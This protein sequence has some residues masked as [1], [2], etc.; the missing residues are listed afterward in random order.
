[1]TLIWFARERLV[2]VTFCL[3]LVILPTAIGCSPDEGAANESEYAAASADNDISQMLS[4]PDTNDTEQGSS[5]IKNGDVPRP[6]R[7]E[8]WMTLLDSIMSNPGDP[9]SL[10]GDSLIAQFEAHAWEHITKTPRGWIIDRRY[11]SAGTRSLSVGTGLR[12]ERALIHFMGQDSDLYMLP[13]RVTRNADGYTFRVQRQDQLDADPIHFRVFFVDDERNVA[14]WF[15]G[16]G[17]FSDTTYFVRKV[18]GISYP[19]VEDPPC[20]CS[21][22]S[23]TTECRSADTTLAAKARTV[24]QRLP[25]LDLGVAFGHRAFLASITRAL[26]RGDTNY[27]LY[28][29]DGLYN[30]SAWGPPGNVLDALN[31]LE[32]ETPSQ[33]TSA[34]LQAHID[35]IQ[36]ATITQALS[37]EQTADPAHVV[38]ALWL[39]WDDG[40]TDVR[41]LTVS[42]PG[43]GRDPLLLEDPP[44]EHADSAADSVRINRLFPD[45]LVS[46]FQQPDSTWLPL[47]YNLEQPNTHV[48]ADSLLSVMEGKWQ[49]LT[50]TDRG[51]IISH[52]DCGA[53]NPS[54]TFTKNNGWSM[55]DMGGQDALDYDIFTPVGRDSAS[56]RMPVRRY[57]EDGD[58]PMRLSVVQLFGSYLDVARIGV[59]ITSGTAEPLDLYI[60]ENRAED[61]PRVGDLPCRCEL[62]FTDADCRIPDTT[63]SA[64]VRPIDQRVRVDVDVPGHKDLLDRIT[65]AA[66]RGDLRFLYYTLDRYTQASA[67]GFEGNVAQ[68]FNLIELNEDTNR[69]PVEVRRLLKHIQHATITRILDASEKK[70]QYEVLIRFNDGRTVTTSIRLTTP[71]TGSSAIHMVE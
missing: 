6:A 9:A 50:N 1:M 68:A 36:Q 71:G 64:T 41:P 24:R 60:R 62:H 8:P 52:R 31:L 14:G 16:E 56:Y 67:W 48:P 63:L 11:C 45:T 61:V 7:L 26:E 38:Y 20:R 58:D 54:I 19:E 3:L 4:G 27:L 49:L 42:L 47:S 65:R 2:E 12:T 59:D 53:M 69:T 34:E 29:I 40:R 21:K 18:P 13:S 55:T 66:E 35:Q 30:V 23:M 43:E 57:Y 33:R 46:P 22:R 32:K 39:R 17:A 28:S 10:P 5:Q 15:A 51:W 70:I 25:D 44:G 37:V